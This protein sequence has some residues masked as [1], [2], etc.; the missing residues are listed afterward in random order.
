MDRP[1][2]VGVDRDGTLIDDSKKYFG[3][4]DDWKE[5]III[6]DGVVEGLKLLNNIGAKI[7]V[8]TNQS[9]V[10]RGYY[11]EARIVEINEEIGRR[12]AQKG[13]KVDGWYFCPYVTREYALKKALPLNSPYIKETG[14]RKPDIGLLKKAASDMGKK[15]TDFDIWFIGDKDVD[16]ITALRA[17]GRGILVLTGESGASLDEVKRL[18]EENPDS[19]FIA[20]NFKE[21]AK[22]IISRKA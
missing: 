8:I 1:L 13:A 10:A 22:I 18:K 12:L 11:D 15:I 6:L 19:V 20:K 16:V 14:D 3:R 4:L 5:K 21:A 17:G 7:A 9:G 2:F